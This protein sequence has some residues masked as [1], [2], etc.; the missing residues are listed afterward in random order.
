MPAAVGMAKSDFSVFAG[1]VSATA[2]HCD[3]AAAAA[4]DFVS[5]V[6]GADTALSSAL[7]EAWNVIEPHLTGT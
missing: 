3:D 4:V 5:G 2:S 6:A 1:V 7:S